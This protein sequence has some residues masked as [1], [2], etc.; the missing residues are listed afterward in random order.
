MAVTQTL[1]V[2]NTK[3]ASI[4][5]VSI[6]ALSMIHAHQTLFV[7]WSSMS[8]F[9]LVRRDSAAILPSDVKS[10]SVN[11]G[12]ILTDFSSVLLKWC[13]YLQLPYM[14]FLFFR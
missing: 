9:A 6:L 5:L 12:G 7:R 4:V 1:N 10:V 14:C 13:I 3:L 2:L 11:S 8:L